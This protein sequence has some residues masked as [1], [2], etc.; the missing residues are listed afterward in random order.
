MIN[1]LQANLRRMG[2]A[3]SMLN[4]AAV[5]ADADV[6]IISEQPRGPPDDDRSMSALD[7]SAQLVLTGSTI[8][9][10]RGVTRGRYHVGAVVCDIAV[11]AC[12]LPPSLTTAQFADALDALRDDCG[13]FPRADLLVAG[14]FNAKVAP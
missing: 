1:F 2:T 11:F 3:R 14:D 8:P 10:A 7:G 6:L 12:Y 4:Q 5:E 13:R 9:A